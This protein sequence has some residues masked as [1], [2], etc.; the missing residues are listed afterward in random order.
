MVQVHALSEDLLSL[1]NSEAYLR[2]AWETAVGSRHRVS[3]SAY[4][5][6]KSERQAG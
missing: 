5:R 6:V 1:L 4:R 3:W 2:A